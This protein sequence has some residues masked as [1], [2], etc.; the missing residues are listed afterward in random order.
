MFSLVGFK[1][2]Y[3]K[4]RWSEMKKLGERRKKLICFKDKRESGIGFYNG[5]SFGGGESNWEKERGRERMDYTFVIWLIIFYDIL[6]NK[7]HYA[8]LG[9]N[10]GVYF[11]IKMIKLNTSINYEFY[12]WFL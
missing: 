7:L 4:K 9:F 5:A 6:T 12:W 11:L 1:V 3:R 2:Y 10:G 8:W